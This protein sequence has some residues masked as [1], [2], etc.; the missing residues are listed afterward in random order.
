MLQLSCQ[1]GGSALNLCEMIMLT[2]SSGTN[3]IEKEHENEG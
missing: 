2:S 1:F 3:Y